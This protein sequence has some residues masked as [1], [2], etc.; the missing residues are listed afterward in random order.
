MPTAYNKAIRDAKRNF[1]RQFYDEIRDVST[2][3]K[4]MKFMARDRNS[5]LNTIKLLNGSFVDSG[6]ETL[7]EMLR[8]HFPDSEVV[9]DLIFPIN[10]SMTNYRK[11]KWIIA[12]RVVT[13]DRLF[14][15]I[16]SFKFSKLLV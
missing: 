9:S 11:D 8:V 4:V 13:Y 12:K 7:V 3:A 5:W 2:M 14:W 6:G 1:W 16:M 15:E 10:I